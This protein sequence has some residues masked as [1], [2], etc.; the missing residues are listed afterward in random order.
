MDQIHVLQL[1]LT[2]CPSNDFDKFALIKDIHL[3]ARKL[4]YKVIYDKSPSS[5]VSLQDTNPP[6]QAPTLAEIQ[7]LEELMSLWEEGD[8]DGDDLLDPYDPEVASLGVSF[9]PPASFKPK[10]TN[11]PNLSTNPNIWAFVQ[12]VTN[13]IEG[14]NLNSSYPSNLTPALIKAIKSLQN[15]PELI[16][17]PADKGGN[18]VVMDVPFYEQMCLDILNNREW[19]RPISKTLIDHYISEYQQLIFGAHQKGIIDSNTWKFLSVTQPRT[20]TFYSLPKLHKSLDHP[21]GRPIVSGRQCLT[22]SASALVDK[23]LAPHVVALPS[24]IKDTIHLLRILDG[25][26][27]PTNTWLVA[28]DVESLYNIIPHNRGISVIKKLIRERGPQY[29]TYGDFVLD[30]LRFILTRN[31][32][33]FGSSHFLQVQGVAMGTKCAPAYANLYLGGWERELFDPAHSNPYRSR[34]ISWYRY[35][36]DILLFWSGTKEEL[37]S[38]V[39]Y[40]TLN[41]FNL[42][43]TMECS[44]SQIHFLD[45]VIGLQPNGQ[46]YTA[47]YRK[48]SSGNTILHAQSAHPEPLLRSIPFSQY[49]RIKRNCTREEDFLRA[50]QELY[51][52]LL[53]RGYSHS[54]FKKSL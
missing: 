9:P 29:D 4:L 15:H 32:F 8:T 40:L 27:L 30:L 37:V 22:E 5:T 35:I 48:P 17:K 36:D 53:D 50:A 20:P 16:I 42:R 19:Y 38:F 7:A 25:Q 26:T 2:F 12:Q 3:F 54:L 33:M 10:S 21:P 51:D 47:L 49:L 14:L 13:T 34:V 6:Q 1:G 23:Y 52:R 45:L 31:Y 24:Y 43:F 41:T 28:L 46:I 44:Q 39:Q 11:F 18:V